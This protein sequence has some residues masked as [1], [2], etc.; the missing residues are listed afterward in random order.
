MFIRSLE[1]SKCVLEEILLSSSQQVQI[2][3]SQSEVLII[4]LAELYGKMMPLPWRV[5]AF[6][7][8]ALVGKE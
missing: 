7:I 4:R 1:V 3:E 2:V 6:K 8:R 5:L